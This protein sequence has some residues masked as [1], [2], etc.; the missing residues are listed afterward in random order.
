[1]ID[2]K[3]SLYQCPKCYLGFL[4]LWAYWK[5]MREVHNERAVGK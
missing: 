5:H 3:Q 1:M 2:D 4:S